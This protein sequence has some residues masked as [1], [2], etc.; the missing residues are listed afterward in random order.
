MGDKAQ[1]NKQSHAFTLN[2]HIPPCL[3]CLG[4][5]SRMIP[6][7]HLSCAFAPQV[8]EFVAGLSCRVV[9]GGCPPFWAVHVNMHMNMFDA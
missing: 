8:A 9:I 6:T 2:V 3:I 7:P 4:M 1:A 5:R